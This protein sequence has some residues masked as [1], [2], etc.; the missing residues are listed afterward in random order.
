[1]DSKIWTLA[2]GSQW[3][4][5][6]GCVQTQLLGSLLFFSSIEIAYWRKKYS[7]ATH[8]RMCSRSRVKEI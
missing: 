6:P 8:R 7:M 1:M 3:L 2:P 5:L 4:H